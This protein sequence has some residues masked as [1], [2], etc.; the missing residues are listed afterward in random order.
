LMMAAISFMDE[1]PLLGTRPDLVGPVR[2]LEIALGAA[3]DQNSFSQPT[4]NLGSVS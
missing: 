2:R 4:Q 3:P 1:A